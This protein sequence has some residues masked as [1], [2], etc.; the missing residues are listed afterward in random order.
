ML[1]VSLVPRRRAWTPA[2]LVLALAAPATGCPDTEAR[3]G[4]F[5][6][7]TKDK[8]PEADGGDGTGTI[9]DVSGNWLFALETV[10][11]P[12]LPLQFYTTVEFTDDGAGGGTANFN[13]QPLSLD[14]GVTNAP[15][16]P[17][18]EPIIVNDVPVGADGSFFVD[19]GMQEVTGEANPVSGGLI[20]ATI[21]LTGNVKSET[22]MCGSFAGEVFQP[23]SGFLDGST[24][25]AEPVDMMDPGAYPDPVTSKCP[26][27]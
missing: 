18:G 2:L 5:A 24:F 7:D 20:V 25:Y 15:R 12:G 22:V 3:L 6:D 17:V 10:L 23:V 8:R 11:G 13:F 26:M 14:P 4:E 27:E 9:A 19:F 16:L 1:R 21:E